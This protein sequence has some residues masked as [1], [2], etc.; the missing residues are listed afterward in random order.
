MYF[1]NIVR[2]RVKFFITINF[3]KKIRNYNHQEKP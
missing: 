3:K 1:K 2:E